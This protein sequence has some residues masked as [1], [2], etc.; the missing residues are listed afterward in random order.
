[1]STEID[2]A[3]TTAPPSGTWALDPVHSS[4]EF[5]V[6]YIVGEFRSSFGNVTA[7]LDTTGEE[8]RLTGSAPVGSLQIGLPPFRDHVLGA[9]FFDSE[10]SPDVT[11]ASTAFRR[12][13]DQLE[14]EGDL[15]IRGTTRSIT[16]TGTLVGP[17]D[18]PH[19]GVALG[20]QLTATVDRH[21][22]GL[23]WNMG[24]PG[25]GKALAGAVR[26]EAGLHFKL[27]NEA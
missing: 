27:D 7:Q 18:D 12:Q 17:V 24:L 14:L 5:A 15:T 21:Q 23:D 13:G 26:I 25:A 4:V 3:P 10:S 16:A 20:I 8:P 1:M 6:F 2:T 22:F 9:E 11:F 19:G